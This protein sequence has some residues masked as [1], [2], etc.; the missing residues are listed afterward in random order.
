MATIVVTTTA[1]TVAADGLTSLREAVQMANSGDEIQLAGDTYSLTAGDL[2]ISN[3]ITILAGGGS[4]IS[5]SSDIVVASGGDLHLDGT[6]GM[7]VS[8][9]ITVNAAGTFSTDS[10][11]LS[12][13]LGNS[14][15]T[16]LDNSDVFG[17]VTS[18]S[19]T[20]TAT[21]TEFSAQVSVNSGTATL[22]ESTV[23]GV[24]TGPG[25][26]VS[27]GTANLTNVTIEGGTDVGLSV[28]GG[29]ATLFHTTITG[30]DGGITNFGTI[31][32]GTTIV[33]GNTNSG[34][35]EIDDRGAII[36]NGGNVLSGSASDV[37]ASVDGG[38]GG[39]ALASN[40][41]PVQTVALLLSPTNPALDVAVSGINDARDDPRFDYAGVGNDGMGFAD[42]GAFELSCFAEGT[43]IKTLE[44]TCLVENLAVGDLVE[45]QD[46]R[47]V[48]VIWIGYQHINSARAFDPAVAP[49]RISA[50]ALGEF[51]DRDLTITAD[52]A[53]VVGE[54]LI[55]ASCLIGLPGINWAP[56]ASRTFF[57]IETEAHEVLI[58]NGAPAESFC[59][60]GNRSAFDNAAEA[61]PRIMPEL[62]LTRI[63]SKRLL[64]QS[65]RQQIVARRERA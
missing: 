18:N 14:G 17:A 62:A 6:S 33:V 39:G 50:Y 64:P 10:V 63:C 46:G 59:D 47:A 5:G 8:T 30:N 27:G 37:F 54:F 15:T 35:V 32:I 20:F 16:T 51:P 60:Y 4:T 24:T 41:G 26:S 3:D 11:A 9:D 1:D 53:L 44:G 13:T 2:T 43:W 19:G 61:Q 28:L 34:G 31:N 48:P 45:T 25:I 40:G 7:T 57:H 36:D 65:L 29:T 12:G 56:P 23:T 55:N 52:H 38:T 42:A 22:N 21:D 49:V 58:A